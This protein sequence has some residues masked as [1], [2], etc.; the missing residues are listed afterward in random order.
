MLDPRVINTARRLVDGQL[1]TRQQSYE[2]QLLSA[3]SEL[4]RRGML[5]SGNAVY[6]LADV[7]NEELRSIATLVWTEL[8][9]TLDAMPPIVGPDLEVDVDAAF[10]TLFG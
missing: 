8:K 10:K 7:A 3:Q 1:G 2:R 9:R 4:A 5:G 6:Q